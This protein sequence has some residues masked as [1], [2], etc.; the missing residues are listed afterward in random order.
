MSTTGIKS[1]GTDFTGAYDA[2]KE[3]YD[4]PFENN[5]EGE[6]EVWSALE[7]TDG[8]EISSEAGDGKGIKID[9]NFSYGGGVYASAED[10][11]FGTS[12]LPTT[13]QSTTTIPIIHAVVQMSGKMMRRMKS[14][15]V[16]FANWAD[17]LLPKRAKR[18]AFHLD[19]MAVGTGTGI[20]GRI[21]T[22]SPDGT[23]V[24]GAAYGI[25]GLEGAGNL[26]LRGD[27]LRYSPN[28]DGS[29][30]RSGVALV[31]N[32]PNGLTGAFS[33][34]TLP[35]STAQNDYVFLGDA[36][37]I[38]AGKEIMGLE[39]IIDDGTNLSS[40]QGL[41]RATYLEM[42]A[43]I[44]DATASSFGATLTEELIDYA[45]STAFE[46]GDGGQPNL[47]MV[48]RSGNR[49]FWKSLKAD[50][51]INDPGGSYKG[52]RANL[53]MLI[54]DRMV[55]IVPARKIPVSRA[56][57]IDT[58]AIKRADIGPGGWLDTTGSVWQRFNDGTGNK[59]SYSAFYIKETQIMTYDPSMCYK[60]TGLAQA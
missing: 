55:K 46:Q 36:N 43:Q 49:A 23:D 5:I 13:V 37:I 54:G 8:F 59:D 7:K 40:I 41:T 17:I 38:S 39:G 57:G 47:L 53:E 50:R 22:A 20:I 31:N 60:I 16:A 6:S 58:R 32:K 27:S 29:S 25:A 45:D 15:K 56:Y 28:A 11:Y 3:V 42:N 34:A 14:D 52:G 10:D 26:I 4:K 33:V 12:T 21:Q 9:H 51:R 2:L 24:I 48:N 18:V 19:R 44:I 35:T 1:S 30:P